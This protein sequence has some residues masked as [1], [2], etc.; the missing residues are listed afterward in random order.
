MPVFDGLLEPKHDRAIASLLFTVAEWHTLA[1]L[2]MHTDLTLGWLQ[3]CTTS[4]GTRIQQFQEYTCSFFETRE[5]PSEEA[6]RSRRQAKKAARN[7]KSGKAK[8]DTILNNSEERNAPKKKVFNLLMIKLH[9][10][11]DNV[12]TIKMFGTSD[13]YST[14]PVSLFLC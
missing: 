12:R 13:S 14:Q 4:F 9:A 7:K 10:L 11:G 5:L 3:Q 6:A 8:Q 1:K 2:R